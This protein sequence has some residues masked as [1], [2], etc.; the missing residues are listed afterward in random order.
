MGHLQ[1]SSFDFCPGL[2]ASMGLF[3]I[4]PLREHIQAQAKLPQYVRRMAKIEL[5]A[6]G[7]LYSSGRR[8]IP[9]SRL[10]RSLGARRRLT[11]R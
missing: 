3:Y 9:A 8:R 10:S 4:E 7:D 11:V 1:V 2:E 5:T 6:Q